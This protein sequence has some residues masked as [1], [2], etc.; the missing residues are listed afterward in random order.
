MFIQFYLLLILHYYFQ[1]HDN[2]GII[3][4]L[5]CDGHSNAKLGINVIILDSV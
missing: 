2:D 1:S 5:I 4:Y 3:K